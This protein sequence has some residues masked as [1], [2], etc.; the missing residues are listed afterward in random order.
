VCAAAGVVLAG[1]GVYTLGKILSLLLSR[2]VTAAAD[3]APAGDPAASLRLANLSHLW[4]V[5]LA[6]LGGGTLLLGLGVLLLR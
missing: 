2:R 4:W 3:E 5:F 6:G 1:I